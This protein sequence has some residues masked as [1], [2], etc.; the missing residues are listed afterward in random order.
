MKK[1]LFFAAACF[2]FGLSISAQNSS[3]KA[4][5][6]PGFVSPNNSNNKGV[7]YNR[8]GTQIPSQQWDEWFNQKVEKRKQDLA[9]GRV[10]ATTYTI[11]IIFHI[12]YSSGEAVGSGH[13]ISQ[14]QVNSQ[15]CVLNADYA[16]IG[17]NTSQYASM[18]FGGHGPFYDYAVANSLPAPDA[19]G[20]VIANS[21]ISFCLAALNPGGTSLPE[22]GIDRVAWQ[23]INGATDP[24]ATGNNNLP[25][26]FDTIIKPATIWDPTKYFNVWVSDGGASG[27]LGYATL[28]SGTTLTGITTIGGSTPATDSTD[29]VWIAYNA[30]GNTGA[31]TSP[32][33]LGRVL[34]HESGHYL[35]LRH[36]W[37]DG[38][39]LTDYCNDTP[40]AAAANYVN[41]ATAYPYHVGTCTGSPSNSPDGEMFMNFM[42]YSD[43]AAMWMFTNDQV[44]RMVTA[45]T[46][47]PNRTGLTASAVNLGSFAPIV[48]FTHPSN[49]CP[50]VA[51]L[52]T[53]ASGQSPT[54]WTWSVTPSAGVTVN[55]SAGPQSPS[56]TFPSTGTYS[57][58][59][60]E[61]N[62]AGTS[63]LTQIVTTAVNTPSVSFILLPDGTV[64]VWDAYVNYSTNV[65][66]A[67][68]YWGDGK[69]TSG[70]YVSHAYDSAGTYNICVTVFSACGDSIQFCQNDSVYRTANTNMIKVNVLQNTSS[71]KQVSGINNRFTVYP[72]PSNGNVT[73]TSGSELGTFSIYNS[74]G[75][76]ILQMKSKNMQE[77]VDINK[78]APG[79]YIIQLQNSFIKL[80]KE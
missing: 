34:T 15:V 62:S 11:P 16:G 56:I 64:H 18:S 51:T 39:C 44:T 63:S 45:L 78:F 67:K 23:S 2:L 3:E 22:P 48:E 19:N 52:F 49:I 55:T 5:N 27:L 13:N 77:Q 29:G 31:V 36:I 80:I 10:T 58:T 12:I 6:K 46:Q 53:D 28:P 54:S 70:L 40:P 20:P 68:W 33:N 42:D 21:G 37:G 50:N 25:F 7:S 43:D 14:A 38:A 57:V 60:I 75:Q 79:V 61:A 17:Y 73:I 66:N 72:N 1:N 30:L 35:G 65:T 8:C 9:A 76:T 59:L 69:D 47:C 4:I 26:L 32:Y 74:L 71:I 41:T 24:V